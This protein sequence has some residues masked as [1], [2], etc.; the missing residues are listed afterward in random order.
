MRPPAAAQRPRLPLSRLEQIMSQRAGAKL[1]QFGYEDVGT[2]RTVTVPQT[3]A[4]QDDYVLG[5]GDEIVVSMRGQEN[6]E[7]RVSVDRNGQV[8]IPRL[9]PLAAS[10]RTFGSFRQDLNAAVRRAYVATQAYVSVGRVRLISVMVAGQVNNPGQQT[11]PGLASVVDAILLSGGVRQTGS[12]RDIRIQRNGREFHVDLYDV[13]TASGAPSRFR[14]ADGDRILVPALGPTVAITGLVRQP[15]IYELPPRGSSLSV[16]ALM[17]LAGG[18]EVRGRYRLSILKILPSGESNLTEISNQSEAV[19]D[20]EILFVQL[21]ADHTVSQVIL[22]GGTGLAGS[23]P[24]VSGTK[25]SEVIKAPGALG[26]SPYTLMGLVVRRNRQTLMRELMAFT[27]VAVLNGREDEILQ[28]DDVVRPLSVNE[29]RLLDFVVRTYLTQLAHDQDQ[30][31]NPLMQAT[32]GANNSIFGQLANQS[33]QGAE[34]EDISS[35]PASTQ[36]Q[37]ITSLLDVPAPGSVLAQERAEISRRAIL[38]QQNQ[39]GSFPPGANPALLQQQQ[40]RP[41]LPEGMNPDVNPALAG[42]GALPRGVLPYQPNINQQF[43]DTDAPSAAGPDRRDGNR[44]D[45]VSPNFTEQSVRK[46]EFASNKEVQTFGEL[47][48]QL[49]IDPLVLINFL[50]DHR[51]RLDGAVRG[52]GSYF[53]GPNATLDDLLSAG[54]GTVNWTDESGVELISTM[55]DRSAGRSETVQKKLALGS[56]TFASYLVH[57]RDQF[58]FMQVSTDVGVGSITVQGEVHYPGTFQILRGEHLSDVL[59]RAGGLTSVAYPQGT[60]YLRKSAALAERQAY[61]RAA[62]QVQDQLMIAMTRVGSSKIDPNTFAAMQSF[63]N[64]LRNHQALGRVSFVA[65]PKVLAAR[66][67]SDPLLEAGDVLYIP[68]RPSTV[69]VLGEVL[70]PGNFVYQRGASLEDY[71]EQAGGYAATAD[72]SLTYIVMPNGEARRVNKSWLSFDVAD[73]PPGSSIVVPRDVTPLD[74]RQTIIDVSQIFSQFA[75]SI[76]SIAVLSKQ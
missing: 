19:H 28:G 22:S 17:D 32:P 67:A 9:P 2:G 62:D 23:Y 3:G 34:L 20:S 66:P 56:G 52:P 33:G 49:G 11:V 50:V 45:F 72:N 68:P 4:V 73:L 55:V 39:A 30:I 51:A 44:Q 64:D 37:A 58:R 40:G 24:V 31:R 29:E 10:G 26:M 53:V 60:V 46:G 47:A 12:L 1:R 15:G 69:A 21:G 71:I 65:D 27:P 75:V 14:L 63:V 61:N 7:F 48:R 70:Q 25:L 54:G 41:P 43:D 38:A 57:P 74:L 13:L 16:R 18:Q 8:L 42:A 59:M 35:V 6:N 5:P 36:R 76:A